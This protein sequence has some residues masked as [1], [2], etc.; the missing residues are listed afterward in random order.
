MQA[1]MTP[2]A[3]T[4]AERPCWPCSATSARTSTCSPLRTNDLP[5]AERPSHLELPLSFSAT[6]AVGAWDVDTCTN[7]R[8]E[9][10]LSEGKCPSGRGQ[11]LR[12]SLSSVALEA[13][14]IAIGDNTLTSDNENPRISVR[15]RSDASAGEYGTCAGVTGVVTFLDDPELERGGA[16]AARFQMELTDCTDEG[17]DAM[18]FAGS[19][20]VRV[21]RSFAEVCK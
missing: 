15:Y 2:A 17:R 16:I 21:R 10:T 18:T 11:E 3:R 5:F 6:R 1:S 8:F 4:T 20:N 9:I 12:I 13:G 19:F 7:P 14:M